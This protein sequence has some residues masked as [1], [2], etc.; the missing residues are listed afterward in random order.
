[1]NLSPQQGSRVRFSRT[2]LAAASTHT[3]VFPLD[4]CVGQQQVPETGPLSPGAW[5][6]WLERA[7][8]YYL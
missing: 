4:Q 6:C 2:Q 7:S 3:R 1:M 8:F 5:G